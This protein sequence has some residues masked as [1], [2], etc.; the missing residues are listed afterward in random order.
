VRF[1]HNDRQLQQQRALTNARVA[2]HQHHRTRHDAT[3]QHT[4][5]L[6]YRQFEAGFGITF[7][8]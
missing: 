6:L 5:E 8:L 1:R 4:G 2:A 3:A 7:D